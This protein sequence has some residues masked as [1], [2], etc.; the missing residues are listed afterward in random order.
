[1]CLFPISPIFRISFLSGFG[2]APLVGLLNL[3]VGHL[4]TLFLLLFTRFNP[5]C[6]ANP[7]RNI[8]TSSSGLLMATSAVVPSASHRPRKY[9]SS[10]TS[11]AGNSTPTRYPL[12]RLRKSLVCDR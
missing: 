1:M 6:E 12:A 5:H 10:G 9:G 3:H 11:D 7:A 2:F 8:R 4:P